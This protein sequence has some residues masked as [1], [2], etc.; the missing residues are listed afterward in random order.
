MSQPTLPRKIPVTPEDVQVQGSIETEDFDE[1]S[2]EDII[3]AIVSN[4][5]LNAI[6]SVIDS[7]ISVIERQEIMIWSLTKLLEEKGFITKEEFLRKV[8]ELNS[9]RSECLHHYD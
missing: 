2:L 1:G 4:Q 3:Q 8:S 5:G 7:L 6:M 9:K